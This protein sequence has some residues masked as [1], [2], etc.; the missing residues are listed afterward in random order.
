MKGF[1]KQVGL[2]TRRAF[3]DVYPDL[4]DLTDDTLTKLVSYVRDARR[5]RCADCVAVT[6]EKCTNCARGLQLTA[7][8]AQSS[9]PTARTSLTP[10]TCARS[11]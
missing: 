6:A 10:S 4:D 9:S 5:S 8:P 7:A 1:F 3:Q 11:N 2:E